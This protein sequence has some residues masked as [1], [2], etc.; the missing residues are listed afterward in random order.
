M[1]SEKIPKYGSLVNGGRPIG[2]NDQSE[3]TFWGMKPGDVKLVISARGRPEFS[4]FNQRIGN[5][6][7]VLILKK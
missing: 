2:E 6:N 1:N 7:S 4:S 5:C 3:R